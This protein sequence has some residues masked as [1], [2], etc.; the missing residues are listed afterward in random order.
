MMEPGES[1]EETARRELKEETGLAGLLRPLDLSHSFWV[2]PSIVRFPDDEPRFNTE[3]CFSM[4][5]PADAE[6]QLELSEHSEFKWCGISEALDLM[7]WEGSKA[8]LGILKVSLQ[9]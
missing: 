8:A 2:D 6:V 9:A 1:P 7:K 4:E 5:V 3:I